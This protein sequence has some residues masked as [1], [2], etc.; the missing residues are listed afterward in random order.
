MS[1]IFSEFISIPSTIIF[2]LFALYKA[3]KSLE[4]V[5]L[6]EPLCPKIAIYF[7]DSIVKLIFSSAYFLAPGYL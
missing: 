5:D 6:P 1:K 2:P 7:P 4:N 3:D